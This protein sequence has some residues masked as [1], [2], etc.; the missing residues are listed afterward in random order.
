MA[1]GK[2][3]QISNSAIH[4]GLGVATHVVAS[5]NV[6]LANNSIFDFK[7][8]GINIESS[9]NVTIDGNLIGNIR[10]RNYSGLDGLMDLSGGVLGCALNEGDICPDLHIMNNIVAGV[11]ITGFSAFGH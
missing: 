7:R 1:F 8:F 11:E 3:S 10:S 2:W 6:L 5:S 4:H 9:S